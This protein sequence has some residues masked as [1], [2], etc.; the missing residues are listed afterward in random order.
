MSESNTIW[1]AVITNS[2]GTEGR[3]SA[4][5]IGVTDNIYTAKRIAKGGGVMGS[6]ADIVEVAP[7]KVGATTYFPKSCVT[8]PVVTGPERDQVIQDEYKK[9]MEAEKAVKMEEMRKQ[10]EAAGLDWEAIVETMKP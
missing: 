7:I 4:V 9:R 8:I 10:V 6:D 5:V 2:D 3:G 1:Y